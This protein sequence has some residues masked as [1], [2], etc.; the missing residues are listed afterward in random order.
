MP[1]PETQAGAE[2]QQGGDGQKPAEGQKPADAAGDQNP[3]AAVL[4]QQLK[5]E[6][7]ARRAAQGKL[8]DLEVKLREFD[9]IDAHAIREMIAEKARLEEEMR[10]KDPAKLEEYHK[11]EKQKLSESFDKKLADAQARIEQLQ[12]TN[13][14][15][16]VTDKVMAQIG[17]HFNED[18][19]DIIKGIVER[20]C[21]IDETG[22]IFIVD[23]GG[24]EMP[25][26][27]NSVLPMS[28]EEFG[29]WLVDR[30]PSLAKPTGMG[31]TRDPNQGERSRRLGAK[32]PTTM[33]EL[34][35]MPNAKEIWAK[36]TPEEKLQLGRTMKFG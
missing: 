4:S 13:K 20:H 12:R 31:G 27:K 25:S 32:L 8:A 23:E 14:T 2:G 5:A 30:K 33:Q 10:K 28:I 21:D 36:L 18:V 6:K 16:T 3:E 22:A 15:L 9:G 1:I 11:I 26:P 34:Q 29:L 19:Q 35:S 7:E 24:K 17:K